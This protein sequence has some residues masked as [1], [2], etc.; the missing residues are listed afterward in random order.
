MMMVKGKAGKGKAGKGQANRKRKAGTER[1]KISDEK[2]KV[3]V[4][5]G[6]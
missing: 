1:W 3:R 6:M 5:S 4:R 2:G